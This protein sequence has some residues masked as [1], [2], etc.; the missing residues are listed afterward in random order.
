[1]FE[2]MIESSS[3]ET[4]A[5]GRRG[6]FFLTSLTLALAF[7]FALGV[8]LFA[9]DFSLGTDNF[10]I[11]ELLAPIAVEAPEPEPVRPQTQAAPSQTDLPQRQVNMLAINEN[12]KVPDSVSTVPN[13]YMSRPTGRFLISGS[14]RNADLGRG[15]DSNASTSNGTGS[16]TP[17]D[18][19][20]DHS[21][22]ASVKPP[23]AVKPPT[24]PRRGPVSLGVINGKATD[25]PKP[26]YSQ[27]AIMIGAK[28][29]VQVQ[30]TIDETGKVISSKAMSGHPLLRP[31]AEKAAWGARF[32]P[33]KLSEVPVKVTGVIV[34]KFSR[35]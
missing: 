5:S 12:P 19:S 1:M 4:A 11:S 31:A 17:S 7:V 13:A 3:V 8:S 21:T 28:G 14:D 10:D 6:Y 15:G 35:N 24:A 34:Y 18:D 33:T 23:P 32:T 30:V 29:D 20:T 25:L 2:K 22:V 9:Q 27:P 26:A 16:G